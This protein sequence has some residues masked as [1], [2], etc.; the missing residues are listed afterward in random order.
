MTTPPPTTGTPTASLVWRLAVTREDA[1]GVAVFAVKG[2]LGTVS[3][4][5][6]VEAL[7][8][9]VNEGS[10]RVVVDLSGVDYLSSAGLL[11]L[12]ALLGRFVA[13]GGELALCGLTVPVRT[14]FELSGLLADFIEA[15]SR[16]IAISRLSGHPT[17]FS[18]SSRE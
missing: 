6:L 16:E 8:R 13:A 12:H 3:S 9:A 11:A 17:P 10:H 7:T 14:S 18:L 15:P 2:R 5:A 4:G 1:E